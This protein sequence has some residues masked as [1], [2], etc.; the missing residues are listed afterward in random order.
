MNSTERFKK[1]ELVGTCGRGFLVCI[2]WVL[3][4]Y[5]SS[6]KKGTVNCCLDRSRNETMDWDNDGNLGFINA[7]VYLK[8]WDEITQGESDEGAEQLN[9]KILSLKQ[10]TE[11]EP[12]KNWGSP[13]LSKCYNQGLPCSLNVE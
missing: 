9:G 7:W 5:G 10:W 6:S 12:M 3:I 11:L 4:A 13:A 1:K 2:C 8:L